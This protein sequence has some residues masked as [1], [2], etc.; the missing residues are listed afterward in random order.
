[1]PNSE[2]SFPTNEKVYEA[3][4]DFFQGVISDLSL[5]KIPL[6]YKRRYVEK[7]EPRQ[8]VIEP[9]YRDLEAVGM[10]S[11]PYEAI[12]EIVEALLN[13]DYYPQTHEDHE[14]DDIL[15]EGRIVKDLLNNFWNLYLRNAEELVVFEQST[16]DRVFGQMEDYLQRKKLPYRAW[17][18]LHNFMMD[19]SILELDGNLR[20]REVEPEDMHYVLEEKYP[21]E[22]YLGPP[23]YPTYI[24]ECEYTV[25]KNSNSHD[26]FEYP[27][28]EFDRVETA[29]RLFEPRGT[30]EYDRGFA[31]PDF[32][33]TMRD[34]P[35][36]TL[37]SGQSGIRYNVCELEVGEETEFTDFFASHRWLIKTETEG[38]FSR[39]LRRLNQMNEKGNDA[40]CIVDCAIAFEE[41]LLKT[42]TQETSFTF[43]LGL[44]GSL[45]LDD[46]IPYNREEIR[47]FFKALYY[48]R[49][50]IVHSDKPLSEIIAEDCFEL[51]TISDPDSR[52]FVQHARVF[53]AEVIK[54]Y[55]NHRTDRGLSIP[56]VNEDLDEAVYNTT[57]NHS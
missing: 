50:E 17:V 53:L 13:A 40:D 33:F 18:F 55:M 57:Y 30:P 43:R 44:R 34:T 23:V 37:R 39:S 41:T 31:E 38:M 49:G 22:E 9:N 5:Q 1:M 12:D 48:A 19:S 6:Q 56:D 24:L 26:V 42:V 51:E 14:N 3:F 52:E 21:R 35:P 28:M 54:E 46:R 7:G 36:A 47:S 2:K 10:H 45:L 29:L 20:I 8:L 11:N 16:F 15:V 25:P 32:P 27:R 4:E